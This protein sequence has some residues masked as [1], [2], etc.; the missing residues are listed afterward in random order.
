MRRPRDHPNVGVRE[1][2]PI[3]FLVQLKGPREATRT[4]GILVLRQD[5]LGS[6][7]QD[8]LPR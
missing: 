3:V 7:E 4:R 2:E 8:R 5:R 1:I 6:S